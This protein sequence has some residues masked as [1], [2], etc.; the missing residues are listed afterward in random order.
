LQIKAFFCKL[1]QTFPWRFS[2]ISRACKSGGPICVFSKHLHPSGPRRTAARAGAEDC[3][4]LAETEKISYHDFIK[5]ES[6]I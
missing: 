5:S 4:P 6:Q 2:A 1:Y 3:S